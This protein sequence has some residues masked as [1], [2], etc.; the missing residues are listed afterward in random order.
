VAA[1]ELTTPAW[2]LRRP[3]RLAAHG[4]R[5]RALRGRLSETAAIHRVLEELRIG[6]GGALVIRGEEGIGKTA[7]L[8]HT[9]GREADLTILR[10]TGVE[11][12]ME[13]PFAALHQLCAPLLDRIDR[14]PDPQRDALCTVFG[15]GRTAAPDRF[16]VGL[17]V[18]GL[19]SEAAEERPVVCAIDD[20]QWLD[21]ASAQV[22]GFV[23]RRLLAES[24]AVIF[25]AREPDD[26]LDGLPELLVEGLAAEDARELLDSVV[27]GAL[28]AAVRERVVAETRGNPLALLELP[29]GLS[30]A[31]L[32][33]GFGLTEALP[34][35][36]HIEASFRRRLEALP[37]AARRLLLVAAAEPVGDPA[38]VWRAAE[39]LGIDATAA[40]SAVGAGLL[41]LGGRVRFCHPLARSAVY[42]AASTVERR[43]VHRA[44]A[45]ATDPAD[46]LDRR[47][48]HL[49]AAADGA[50]ENVATELERSA[51]RAQAR[52]GFAAAA[53]FLERASSMTVDARRRAERAL[54]AAEAKLEAGAREDAMDLLFR[55]NAGPLDELERAR[56]ELVQARIA[57]ALRRS[58]DAPDLLLTA[59]R[60]LEPLDV[61]LARDAYLEALAAALAV[62]PLTSGNCVLK[63]AR[64]AR[65]APPA[66]RP[67]RAPDLLLDGLALLV[68]EGHNAG[69]ETLRAALVA[70]GSEDLPPAEGMRWLWL[71]C[72]AAVAMWDDE[73]HDAL[74]TRQVELVRAAGALAALPV[75]IQWKAGAELAAGELVA[76]SST[77]DELAEIAEAMSVRPSPSAAIPFTAI[78]GRA[79]EALELIEGS[80]PEIT[81]SGERIGMARLAYGTAVLYNGLGR[82][83]DALDAAEQASEHADQLPLYGL[84]LFEMVEA[85]VRAGAGAQAADAHRRLAETTSASG[86][87][88]ALGIEA[89]AFALTSEGEQADSLYRE[90]IDRL[91]HTRRRIDLA[92][93]ELMYGEWLRRERRRVEAREHLRTA[94][95]MLSTMG[96]EAFAERARRELLATGET[97][98]KRTVETRDELT[99]QERQ[100]ARLARDGL[101]N[102]EIGERLFISPRTVKYHLR[103]VFM[104]LEIISRNEL[105]RVLPLEAAA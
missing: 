59:A 69:A 62:G 97:A 100:I 26:S 25:A 32:A 7:L 78:R 57:F 55:A 86:T 89:C 84:A 51:G 49:A 54:A 29:R 64:A 66:P 21:R 9:I 90:A 14:L 77:L 35:A 73:A 43:E 63:A 67:P 99:A 47:A 24:V 98:R 2:S 28:D 95:E 72:V 46:D 16:L 56:V 31:Q 71:A 53:A 96:V 76:A 65:Q 60:R 88:W 50:D 23:A 79:E 22:L 92:R 1:L 40:V 45:Q 10:A 41:E 5:A 42:R 3:R 93:A 33:G 48:W 61:V 44:L 19:L 37:Q 17:A 30:A 104:K 105:D 11:C 4:R 87:D 80:E 101:S 20:A 6:R 8:D 58:S 34:L 18:L 75:A 74:A 82:Y 36:G 52:G 38:L 70:F 103:K 85:A 102:P 27:P 39:T 12:E 68:T 83:E 13:L 15:V 91:G 81:A 94:H